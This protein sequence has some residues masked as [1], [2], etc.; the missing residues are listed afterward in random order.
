M[1][2]LYSCVVKCNKTLWWTLH[3]SKP[4]FCECNLWTARVITW[5]KNGMEMKAKSTLVKSV[6][7]AD[8]TG[9]LPSCS[10]PPIILFKLGLSQGCNCGLLCNFQGR[11]IWF[12]FLGT[13]VWSSL[14]QSSAYIC[15]LGCVLWTAQTLYMSDL[16]LWTLNGSWA[17]AG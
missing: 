8:F 4:V 10:T 7:Q 11:T 1:S 13:R 15:Q 6:T 9:L 17:R 16:Q 14:N 3:F 5:S 2:C 12:L